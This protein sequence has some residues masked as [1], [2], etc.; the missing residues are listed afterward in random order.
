[1]ILFQ[2]VEVAARLEERE[3]VEVLSDEAIDFE[4]AKILIIEDVLLNRELLK[5]FLK[6][7]KYLELSEAENGKIAIEKVRM[8]RPDLILMDMKM[9][10]MDGYEATEYL[11]KDPTT[12]SIP[13][14]A[15]T[16]SVLNHTDWERK[17]MCDEYIRKPI[18]MEELQKKMAKFLRTKEIETNVNM[19]SFQ[20]IKNPK[21]LYEILSLE[22]MEIWKDIREILI[23]DNIIVFAKDLIELGELH[24]YKELV[25]WARKLEKSAS[26]YDAKE[27]K[28]TLSQFP[29]LIMNLRNFIRED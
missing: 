7:F 28:R 4:P 19:L 12:S 13:I 10:E 18:R 1:M 26:L 24:D 3:K 17:A 29:E 21:K 27:M 22:R 25:A 2:D 8:S 14:I 15:I 20:K 23:V 5:R 16:A 9:P 11:K 6:K